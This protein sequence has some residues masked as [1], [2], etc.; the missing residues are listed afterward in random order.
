M[1]GHYIIPLNYQFIGHQ[2]ISKSNYI[3]FKKDLACDIFPYCSYSLFFIYVS[4]EI[5][6]FLKD[7]VF[8]EHS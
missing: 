3:I 2:R 8:K 1:K 4:S 6:N 7:L 5:T